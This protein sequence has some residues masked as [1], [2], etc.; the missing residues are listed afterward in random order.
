MRFTDIPAHSSLKKRLLYMAH[1]GHV[2]H[3][4]LF[5]GP[6]GNAGLPLAFAFIRYLNCQHPLPE[7][8]CGTCKS[9]LQLTKLSHPDVK[10]TFP[11]STIKAS[12]E[13]EKT[14]NNLLPFWRSFAQ[15][16]PYADL[17][18]W[19]TYVG[20]EHKQLLI[21]KTEVT[22]I[23]QYMSLR[24]F[25]ST[26]KVNLIWLPEYMHPT[27]AHALLKTLEEPPAPHTIFI[28][29]STAPE[30]LL[31]T[32]RSRLQQMYIPAFTEEEL[33]QLIRNNH[34]LSSTEIAAAARLAAGNAH[35]AFQLLANNQRD[36][37]EPFVNWLR[38]CYAHDFTKLLAEVEKFQAAQKEGQKYF[39]T[40]SL[41]M[42]RQIWITRLAIE[43]LLQVQSSERQLIE[44]LGQTL[45]DEAITQIQQWIN[46]AHYHIDRNLNAKILFLNLSLKI[47]QVFQAIRQRRN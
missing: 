35:K 42:L 34:Q 12:A 37:F 22:S 16:Q 41:H 24:P 23:S 8:A 4:H 45:D 9:C 27:A 44:K 3:A 20:I 32:M 28:L 15:E 47:A 36:L 17:V 46:Q 33:T 30:R 11:I 31:S 5:W 19:S 40:Y 2:P 7:D 21:S 18:D 39:L 14:S 6:T 38:V 43:S 29:V 25:E 10:F 13:T 1:S 26:Y